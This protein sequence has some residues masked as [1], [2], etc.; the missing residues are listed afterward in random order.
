MK[1]VTYSK[2]SAGRRGATI[3]IEGLERLAAP[4]QVDRG[5]DS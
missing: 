5:C 2:D 3:E 1:L 4:V